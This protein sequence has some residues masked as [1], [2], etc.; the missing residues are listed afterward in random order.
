MDS[1]HLLFV[2]F[3]VK[4][5]QIFL[6]T[7]SYLLRKIPVSRIYICAI[8]GLLGH[9]FQVG[10]WTTFAVFFIFVG[11]LAIENWRLSPV[12]FTSTI[13]GLSS[14]FLV[15]ASN[16]MQMPIDCE[17]VS[18]LSEIYVLMSDKTNLNLLGDWIY[19]PGLEDEMYASIGDILSTLGSY[20]LIFIFLREHR[21][22]A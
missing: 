1:A 14:N 20:Y 21:K 18:D 17:N 11:T 7:A 6:L 8:I 15:L 16:G 3:L 13:L 19:F 12:G 10:I 5:S 2:F 22:L 4:F 9:I